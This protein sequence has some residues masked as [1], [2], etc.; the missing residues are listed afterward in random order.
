MKKVSFLLV[1]GLVGFAAL[2]NANALSLKFA[3]QSNWD[4]HEMYFSPA[5]QK[6]WGPDQLGDDV[7]EHGQTF[8]LSKIE[9]D[10]YDVKL[11]DEDGD[12]CVVSDVDFDSSESFTLTESMLLGC[13][14]ATAEEADEE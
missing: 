9:K 12:E 3:N 13:Q 8:T 14:Q 6:S 7:I 10:T 2:P 1:A 4:I 5:D 11:V